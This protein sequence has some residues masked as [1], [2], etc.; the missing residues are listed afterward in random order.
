MTKFRVKGLKLLTL[1]ALAALSL[2][3]CGG[4]KVDNAVATD[5]E[6]TY[7]LKVGYGQ[8]TGAALFDVADLEGYF[9]DENLEVEGIGFASSA[10]GLNALQAG[11]IDVGMTFGTAA[12]LTFIA[13]GSDF[14]IIGGHLEG[15]H[16]IL[17]TEANAD[18]FKTLQDFVGKKVGTI[19]MFTSDIV[20]RGALE[21][22][23]IDW[24]ND[25][26]IVEFKT[27]GDLLQ[28]VASGK[29][30][31]AVSAG[32]TYLAAQES[33]LKAVLWSNDLNP[34][35]V[36][37]RIVTQTGDL[38]ED[39]GEAYKRFLKALIRAERV[40]NEHPE[41]AVEAAMTH[42]K[43]DEKTVDSIVNEEN[44]NYSADPNSDEVVKMWSQMQEIGY[45][46]NVEDIAIEKHIFTDLYL[47]A[48][49]ELKNEHPQ[50][51][52]YFEQLEARF[53]EQNKL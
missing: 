16:P 3:A 48:I 7:S 15:G 22:Q 5:E 28:A 52:A 41:R 44:A 39:D 14:S 53:A 11:K 32:S 18:N 27:G 31:V 29:V 10:D 38:A 13:N 4:E 42:Y 40:K 1:S 23:G 43:L 35:H 6:K 30:D 49:A 2:A 21:E 24:K 8:G 33:G 37:C 51:V 45:V 46:Q 36:C 47:Q 17:A 9:E 25:L 34:T 20:F 26:Q 19:R 50:D 12:P